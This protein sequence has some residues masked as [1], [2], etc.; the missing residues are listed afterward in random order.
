[1]LLKLGI[2]L[3]LVISGHILWLCGFLRCEIFV[4]IV[5]ILILASLPYFYF[6]SRKETYIPPKKLI[7]V[8]PIPE[9]ESPN[10]Y[11]SRW[12]QLHAVN[13][14]GRLP[15]NRLA[16]LKAKYRMGPFMKYRYAEELSTPFFKKLSQPPTKAKR[17]DDNV[18]EDCHPQLFVTKFTNKYLQYR[19]LL[20]YMQG[21]PN[22]NVKY[23]VTFP[24][25]PT[26]LP[27]KTSSSSA[28]SK[29]AVPIISEE[30][31]LVASD[32]AP[33]FEETE[34]TERKRLEFEKQIEE[35]RKKL[36]DVQGVFHIIKQ[37][38]QLNHTIRD[39]KCSKISSD[40]DES[41]YG[42][43]RLFRFSRT[44]RKESSEK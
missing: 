38:K 26:S 18:M 25:D 7:P 36:E 12:W 40:A 3:V 37:G 15:L 22:A 32:I 8:T 21:I 10:L 34:E 44:K 13:G 23:Q 1:M 35:S 2:I 17:Y 29:T 14:D 42:L 19:S 16:Y 39:E 41:C 9:I 11:I 20:Y 27:E 31:F 6:H 43:R 5:D 4:L 30:S 24:E 33:G 28:E